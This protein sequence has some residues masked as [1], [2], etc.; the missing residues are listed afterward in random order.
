MLYKINE[1]NDKLEPVISTWHPKESALEGYLISDDSEGPS[2]LSEAIFGEPLLILS[3]QVRTR[4]NKR[5]D[6]LALDRAGNGV[7]VELKRDE[8]RLG[9][10]TQAL[11]YL[12]DFSHYTGENFID[13]FSDGLASK[14]AKEDIAAFIGGAIESKNINSNSRIILIARS[15]DPSIFSMGEWLSSKGVSFR[16]ITYTP[17][18][19][20][21]K[22]LLSFS[23][24]FDRTS[25]AIFPLAFSSNARNP[26]YYW[27]NIARHDQAWWELLVQENQIPACFE[28]SPGDQGEKIL[29]SYVP[30]DTIIAYAKGYGAVGWAVVSS[31][32]NYRLI[33]PGSKTDGLNGHCLHR[34]EVK[35]H[36]V[37]KQLSDGIPPDIIKREFGI[38]HPI[39]TSVSINLINNG[40]R[41]IEHMSNQFEK[42]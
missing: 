1:S 41:L 29:T 16:C 30:G 12:A 11:Q 23:I 6:I 35:W 26:G 15:F 5:A 14:E 3:N 42:A 33:Q 40:K 39:R 27:H 7:I 25:G 21:D 17:I 36:A 18:R 31:P 32:M 8:G 34:L 22:K 20:G 2:I 19:F 38:Y 4:G 24:A 9:V 37:A 10:E 28:D 13:K